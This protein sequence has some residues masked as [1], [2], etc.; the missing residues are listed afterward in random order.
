MGLFSIIPYFFENFLERKSN[1]NNSDIKDPQVSKIETVSANL[2]KSYGS[3]MVTELVADWYVSWFI[4]D[5]SE[6]H[7]DPRAAHLQIYIRVE[8]KKSQIG[9]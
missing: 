9:Y 3:G 1:P 6:P 5:H 8:L 4:T 7:G 2:L